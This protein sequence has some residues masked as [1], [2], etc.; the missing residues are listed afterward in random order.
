MVELAVFGTLVLFALGVLIR[1][2]LAFNARQ[3][4]TM[5]AFR[6]A[7]R[8]AAAQ[9]GDPGDE[10]AAAQYVVVQDR[11]VPDPSEPF[12]L[13]PRNRVGG[14]AQVVWGHFLTFLDGEDDEN[15]VWFRINGAPPIRYD[16][17]ELPS[18]KSQIQPLGDTNR[19]LRTFAQQHRNESLAAQ[20]ITNTTQ[21]QQLD[22]VTTTIFLKGCTPETKATCRQQ[23]VLSAFQ[24]LTDREWVTPHAPPQ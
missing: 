19:L 14:S 17:A 9:R 3:E 7:L 11:M 23:N 24:Q 10:L 22:A 21:A 1:F 20:T 8:Q 12:G 15:R 18:R 2:G 5:E 16:T 6:N 4:V 13:N